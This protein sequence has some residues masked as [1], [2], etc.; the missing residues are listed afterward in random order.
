MQLGKV[1]GNLVA[2]RKSGCTQ[3]IR[4]LVVQQLDENLK[5]KAKYFISVDSVNANSGDVVLTCSSSSARMTARTKGI[6]ADN[7]IVAIVDLVSKKQKNIY[8]K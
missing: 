5:P 2:T 8:Q 6:C 7:A 1:I 4:L 3:G